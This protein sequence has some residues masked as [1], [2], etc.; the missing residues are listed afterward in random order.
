MVSSKQNVS[1]KKAKIFIHIS[2]TFSRN[3]IFF[4]ENEWSKKANQSV[5]CITTNNNNC[6]KTN[7]LNRILEKCILF[8]APPVVDFI[9]CFFFRG[10]CALYFRKFVYFMNFRKNFAFVLKIVFREIFCFFSIISIFSANAK[11]ERN[12]H[13]NNFLRKYFSFSLKTLLIPVKF[14]NVVLCAIYLFLFNCYWIKRVDSVCAK[15]SYGILLHWNS[16]R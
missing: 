5:S 14:R 12:G 11:M 6:V 9:L 16:R 2:Q 13:E 7:I 4:R 1:R 10:I 15:E 8:F 3:F